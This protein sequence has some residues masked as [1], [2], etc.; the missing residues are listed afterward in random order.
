SSD[1]GSFGEIEPFSKPDNDGDAFELLDVET[2]EA[3]QAQPFGDADEEEPA[4]ASMFDAPAALPKRP[5]TPV[6]AAAAATVSGIGAEPDAAIVEG[7][8]ARPTSV[9]LA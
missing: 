7:P 5:E 6:P 2:S 8:S 4:E 1:F 3:T 9:V